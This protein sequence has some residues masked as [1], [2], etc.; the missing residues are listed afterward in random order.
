M[1]KT[2]SEFH[3]S[4]K[5]FLHIKTKKLR[6][7]F[8]QQG[9]TG[10]SKVFLAFHFQIKHHLTHWLPS[11]CHSDIVKTLNKSFH[12]TLMQ[13]K[14]SCMQLCTQ[15]QGGVTTMGR[16]IWHISWPFEKEQK[17]AETMSICYV[18]VPSHPG[19]G[20]IWDTQ[21][22]KVP[23]LL[24]MWNSWP[25]NFA[26]WKSFK[27]K[28]YTESILVSFTGLILFLI[29]VHFARPKHLFK[30]LL[31]KS[32]RNYKQKPSETQSQ[33]PSTCRPSTEYYPVLPANRQG[34]Y[35]LKEHSLDEI[36]VSAHTSTEKF[37]I[38]VDN[39]TVRKYWA[40][41]HRN[42]PCVQYNQFFHR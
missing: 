32:C 16:A 19:L 37:H 18:L 11:C 41:F 4:E 2:T 20:L 7:S 24:L 23:F 36:R 1:E 38:L 31:C 29:L 3:I 10:G 8:L 42:L 14:L 25:L 5:N 6:L 13:V 40:M 30:C 35:K 33:K 28:L 22:W 17:I 39:Q 21:K 34:C 26:N 15:T 9:Y 12:W 27:A